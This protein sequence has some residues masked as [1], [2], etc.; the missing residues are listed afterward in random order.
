MPQNAPEAPQAAAPR[1][2]E[3][4]LKAL[5][6]LF[7]QGRPAEVVDRARAIAAAHPQAGFVWKVLGAALLAAGR[8]EH[9]AAAAEA[10]AKAVELLP[11]DAQAKFNLGIALHGLER[12]A[13]A[14]TSYRAA[15][16]LAPVFA[17]AH[18]N[19]G[20]TLHALGRTDEAIACYR[21]SLELNPCRPQTHV[22]LGAALN[23]LALHAEA[24]AA[25]RR[26]LELAPRSAPA[27]NNLGMA[28][29]AQRRFAEAED[30][31]REALALK[32]DYPE[33]HNNLG[34][35]LH[36]LGRLQ[37][38]EE[39]FRQ[40][41]AAR[42]DD[43]EALC[44]LGNVLH[45][46]G[47]LRESAECCR[48]ALAL[49]PHIAAT[50]SNL[51]F[52]LS[53]D[54]ACPPQDYLAEAKRF[55][56]EAARKAGEPYAGWLC[57]PDPARLRV[58]FVSADLRNHPVGHFLEGVL[59]ALD[60]AQVELYAYSSAEADD[61]LTERIRPLFAGWRAIAGLDDGAAAR[62]I[63]Q[64]G[65]HVLFDLSGHTAGN[66]L[67]TFAR[68]PAPVQACWLGYFASTGL[69]EMDY[70]LAD[71]TGAP[72]DERRWFTEQVVLLPETRLCF[73]VP[74]E[75]PPVTPLPALSG[76]GVTFGCFQNLTKLDDGVLDLWAE[77]LAGLPGA[78]LRVQ[79]RQLDDAGAAAA[80]RE[81][82]ARRGV[83]EERLLL[84]GSMARAAYLAAYSEV[85]MVLDTFPY[86]GGT[87][88][89]EALWMGVPTLTLAGGS[90]L[91]RQGAS[92]LTAAGLADWIAADA[93][94]YKAKALARA[95]DLPGLA[96]LRQGLRAHVRASALFDAPRFARHFEA[97]LRELWAKRQSAA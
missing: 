19:L 18:T 45:T 21:R 40:G 90:L 13:E 2:N 58:G 68:R 66:R 49:K 7:N 5:V 31:F 16:E 86:P 61:A 30:S 46:Q 55:G 47:R 76:G 8:P 38:A 41:L 10:N 3:E 95:A 28:L 72:E 92:L 75:A 39:C 26:A 37:E 33:A 48:K 34:N 11:L 15:L 42:P 22:N 12:Y 36:E 80:L 79:N 17:D 4:E 85:D 71:E 23:A 9:A 14:E 25:C 94:E 87:T 91:G 59:A 51:L 82:L 97:L 50:R 73:T 24:E 60:P 43:A 77:I 20:N 29:N 65:I 83:T 52:V 62:L 67:E 74:A 84:C 81:R 6:A 64:D 54:P 56:R 1:I 69:A 93:A 32:P 27:H 96:A 78:R 44:N 88:T 63:R 70:L 57:E 53:H 35:A 89:C